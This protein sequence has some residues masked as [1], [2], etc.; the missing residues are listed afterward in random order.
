MLLGVG[1]ST[2]AAPF[3]ATVADLAP[4]AFVVVFV[5]VLL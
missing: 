3:V 1:V 2:D 4:R 5:V